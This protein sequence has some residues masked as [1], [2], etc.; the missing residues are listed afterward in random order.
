MTLD[1]RH[2]QITYIMTY[3][4]PDQPLFMYSNRL[5]WHNPNFQKQKKKDLDTQLVIV[6][7]GS[8]KNLEV[9]VYVQGNKS[10]KIN[11]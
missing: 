6:N 11:V 4:G 1:G 5:D 2:R 7:L 9:L 3:M 8:T 10:D